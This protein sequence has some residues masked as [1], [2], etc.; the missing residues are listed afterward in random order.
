MLNE[1]LNNKTILITGGAGSFG[2]AFTKYVKKKYKPKKIIIFSR[3]EYKHYEFQ[4]QLTKEGLDTGIR[5]FI[6]DVRDLERLKIAFKDVDYVIHAAALKHVEVAEY[7]PQEFIKTNISG[8]QNII[9]ASIER[10]VKKVVALST[11]KAAHPINLY[12]ATKLVSDKL[13]CSANHLSG[14]QN[15]IFSVVRYGNVLNSSGSVIPYYKK[16]IS[17]GISSLPVTHKDMNRFVITLEQGVKFVLNSLQEMKGSEIFVP[18]LP[19]VKILDIVKALN[20]K[21]NF[22]GL[23]PGEKKYEVLCPSDEID[24]TEIKKNYFIINSATFFSS[25]KKDKFK[26]KLREEYNSKNNKK[27]LSIADIKKLIK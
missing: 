16:L 11:D 20:K 9:D 24:Q 25:S 13:F 21:P 8:A 3:D 17:E 10:K 1:I 5:F 7:N 26:K 19:S 23:R 12:G 14:K 6:G 2:R 15:T 27:F 18:F 4:K 22:I